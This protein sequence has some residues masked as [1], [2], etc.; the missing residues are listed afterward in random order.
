MKKELLKGV[1]LLALII[2]LALMT[3]VASVNANAPT[4]EDE[5]YTAVAR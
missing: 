4:S 1:S 2:M 5:G 3:A